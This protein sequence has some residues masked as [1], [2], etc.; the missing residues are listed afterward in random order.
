[1]YIPEIIQ[2]NLIGRYNYDLLADH[3]GINNTYEVVAQKYYQFLFCK[4]IEA[5]V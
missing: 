1:M 3:F 5:Y 2:T 4:D